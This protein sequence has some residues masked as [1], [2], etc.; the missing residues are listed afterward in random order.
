MIRPLREWYNGAIGSI[1]SYDQI[2]EE[3]LQFNVNAEEA[4]HLLNMEEQVSQLI[5]VEYRYIRLAFHPTL[6]KFLIIG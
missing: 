2:K 1:F 3:L 4:R 5:L 6:H